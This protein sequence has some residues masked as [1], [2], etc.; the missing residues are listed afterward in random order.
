[1]P[2]ISL[3]RLR[4]LLRAY[5]LTPKNLKLA[6]VVAALE[7]RDEFMRSA[8]AVETIMMHRI[9]LPRIVVRTTDG[10]VFVADRSIL[11]QMSADGRLPVTETERLV[12]RLDRRKRQWWSQA[13]EIGLRGLRRRERDAAAKSRRLVRR[14]LRRPSTD[15][16]TIAA[17]LV[18]FS[19][20]VD[21][22]GR[23]YELILRELL[24]LQDCCALLDR[25]REAR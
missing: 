2:T 7:Q 10:P 8:D 3:P 15:I 1:M 14:F 24:A 17:K 16:P 18:L 20:Q 6:G 11:T 13:S 25:S 9:G 23:D 21:G 22:S 5:Q 19:A 12:R 4:D